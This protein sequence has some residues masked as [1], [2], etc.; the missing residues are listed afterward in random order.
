MAARISRGWRELAVSTIGASRISPVNEKLYH[1]S[2]LL[3]DWKGSFA[4]NNQAI[5]FKVVSIT[6]DTAQ[7]EYSHNG[8][9]EVGTANVDKNT[10]TYGNV[11]IATRDGQQGAL[12]FSFGIVRQAAVLAKVAAPAADQNRLVGSWIGSTDTLSASFQVLSI[13]GRDAQ[14]RYNI[15]GQSGQ[16]VGDVVNNSVLFGKISFSSADGLNGKLI[17]QDPGQALSSLDVT[18]FKPTTA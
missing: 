18:K 17:F 3:G 10:I 1:Q 12:E 4:N 16:G 15:D 8:H 7:I 6:G 11:T 9:K 13:T 2:N 5:E 14:V